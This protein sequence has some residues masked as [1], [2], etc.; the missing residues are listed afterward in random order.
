MIKTLTAYT[1]EIDDV[2]AAVDAVL[3]QLD[4]ENNLCKNAA[5][6]MTCYAE[7]IESGVVEALC[8]R[9]PF[10]VVG[11]TTFGNSV[12]GNCGQ[13]MLSLMVLTSDD[14]SF[15]CSVSDSIKDS[16]EPL[17]GGYAR[18]CDALADEPVMAFCMA[19]LIYSVGGDQIVAILDEVT[20]GLPI[21]GTLAVD[22]TDD[23]REAQT[24]Y[25]GEAFRESAV[26]LLLSGNV[27]PTYFI[28]SISPEKILKQEAIIT[29][30]QEN[31]LLEVN[32]MS[33]LSYLQSIGLAR[34]GWVEGVNSIPFIVNYNDGTEPV[35]RAIFALTPEGYAVCGGAMKEGAT[36]AVGLISYQDVIATALYTADKAL[37]NGKRNGLLLFSCLIRNMALGIETLAEME[38]IHEN[39]SK[40]IP[41]QMAYSGGEICP[42]YGR[43][44]KPVNRFHNDTIVACLL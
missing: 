8:E 5:G 21:F 38:A 37:E 9:L 18:A 12:H 32:N 27:E 34:D 4:L 25:N 41:Y 33:V 22:H 23:Y 6:I 20:G 13:L 7:F 31:L 43:D 44:G 3:E 11:C 2:Q 1:E 30:S 40:R 39:I 14:V 17:A 19:P 36:L 10:A 35:A 24:I 42:V 26:L 15:S 28:A 16:L 29:K